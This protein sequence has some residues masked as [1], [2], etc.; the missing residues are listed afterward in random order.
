MDAQLYSRH[1]QHEFVLWVIGAE[2]KNRGKYNM[3]FLPILLEIR[4]VFL[5]DALNIPIIKN[6]KVKFTSVEVEAHS[7]LI[8][9][10]IRIG[11]RF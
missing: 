11:Q 10:N 3:N 8:R 6:A 7:K 9:M 1:A 5:D 2:S 4:E